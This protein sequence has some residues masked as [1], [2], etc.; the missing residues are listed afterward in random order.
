MKASIAIG[1]AAWAALVASTGWAQAAPTVGECLA[2]NQRAADLF[3]Q[4]KLR[5]AQ[6]EYLTCANPSCPE[7]VR[8]ECTLRAEEVGAGVPTLMVT[9]KDA[10]GND[11]V[12]VKVTADGG[13]VAEAMNGTPIRF[14]PGPHTFT[15]EV[16]GQPV[17]KRDFVLSQGEKGRRETVVIGEAA[18][19]ARPEP[20]LTP[21]P[22]APPP[23]LAL[24]PNRPPW[25]L[26]VAGSIGTA[27]VLVGAITGGLTFAKKSVVQGECTRSGSAGPYQCSDRGFNAL[28][29][30]RA[31]GLT[32]SIAW[33]VAAAGLGTAA[34][35]YFRGPQA[36]RTQTA[37][38]H[39]SIATSGTALQLEARY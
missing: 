6:T 30:G 9:V 15:F 14:D 23:P 27:G 18:P 2:A 20:V 39:W 24:P 5:S 11:L 21:I 16:P 22:P 8:T 32:S 3:A 34:V 31:L 17:V 37:E 26:Y 4:N 13:P 28:N 19:L 33:G 36:K 10:S 1:L 35:L 38:W 25:G 12:S 7:Q 29:A